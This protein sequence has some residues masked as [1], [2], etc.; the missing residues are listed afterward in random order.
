VQLAVLKR[1][2]LKTTELGIKNILMRIFKFENWHRYSLYDRLYGLEIIKYCNNCG[3]K[4]RIIE[5]G[6]GLGDLLRNIHFKKRIGLDSEK[7]VL[8]AARLYAYITFQFDISYQL[9]NFPSTPLIG[10]HDI[11][12]M[13]GWN[14][15]TAPDLLKKYFVEYFNNNL[16]ENGCI[17]MDTVDNKDYEYNH[18]INFLTDSIDCKLTKLGTYTYNRSI[19]IILK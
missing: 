8:K 1:K 15:Q 18:D 5:I 9:F 13:V 14:H 10:K 19:W 4:N 11:I 16:N 7:N 17:I 12:L 6:C 3:H 2:L